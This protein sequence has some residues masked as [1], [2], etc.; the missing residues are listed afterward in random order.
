MRRIMGGLRGRGAESIQR[1]KMNEKLISIGDDYWIENEAGEKSFYVDG[2]A[3]RVRN[4]L[5]IKDAQ[6]NELYKLKEK[7][8]RIRDTMDILDAKDETVATIKKALVTPLRDRWKVEVVNGPEMDVQGNILDHE[9][10]IEAGREKVAEVSKKWFRI[11]DTYGVEIAPGQ[12]NALILAIT[13]AL[14]QMVH[15]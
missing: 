1:Y 9:Y 15:D 4:I 3:L 13:A 8:L 7:L 6:G 14:D 10:R 2:K 5:I 11:R 12:D